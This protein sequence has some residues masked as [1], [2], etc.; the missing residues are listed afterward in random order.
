[1]AKLMLSSPILL[2]REGKHSGAGISQA[3]LASAHL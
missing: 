2:V 3:S 1:M